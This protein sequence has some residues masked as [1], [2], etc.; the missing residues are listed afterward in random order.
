MAREGSRGEEGQE[1]GRG[2]GGGGLP[3]GGG[4]QLLLDA[5]HIGVDEAGGR[6]GCKEGRPGCALEKCPERPKAS[7][8]AEVLPKSFPT[9]F[10]ALRE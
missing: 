5:G 7:S 3:L 2:G 8:E 10:S 9:Y 1:G 6:G 4:R